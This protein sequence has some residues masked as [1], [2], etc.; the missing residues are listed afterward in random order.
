MLQDSMLAADRSL[1]TEEYDYWLTQPNSQLLTF[2]KRMKTTVKVS[3]AQ[4]ADMGSNF[5]SI[6]PYFSPLVPAHLFDI[7]LGPAYIPP[8]AEIPLDP[9]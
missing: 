5:R 3:V 6:D 2:I 8:G 9:G 7:V 4:A 1:F